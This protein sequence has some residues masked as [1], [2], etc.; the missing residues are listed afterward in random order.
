MIEWGHLAPK[1]E[2]EEFLE[3]AGL[4]VMTVADSKNKYSS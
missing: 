1:T 2:T 4:F 3:T